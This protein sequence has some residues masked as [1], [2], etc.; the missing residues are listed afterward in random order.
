M[1]GNEEVI[2]LD[3]HVLAWLTTD[4]RKLSRHASSAIRRASRAGGVGISAI[5]LWELSWLVAHQRM[6]IRGTL[7]SYLE[8]VSGVVAVHPITA[9]VAALATQ[10]PSDYSND[11]CARLIGATALAEGIVLVT[12]DEKIRSFPGLQTLW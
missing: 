2:L 6:M 11:P 9:K 4:S 8:E 1:G 7:E 10:F 3:T 5:T 12:R